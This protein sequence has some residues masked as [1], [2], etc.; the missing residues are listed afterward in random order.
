MK[1]ARRK[2]NDNFG[3]KNGGGEEYQVVGNLIH[4]CFI[5]QVDI[6]LAGYPAFISLQ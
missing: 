1:W 6:R 3:E 4:L 2:W 5:V